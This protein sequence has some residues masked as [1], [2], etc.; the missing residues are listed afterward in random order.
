MRAAGEAR[1]H[2]GQGTHDTVCV[3]K[4]TT[5]DSSAPASRMDQTGSTRSYPTR[6]ARY[7]PY[8]PPPS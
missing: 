1:G 7:G 2:E 5:L 4:V 3:C 6:V 8:P